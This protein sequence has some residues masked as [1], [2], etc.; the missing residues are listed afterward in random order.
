MP[1][2]TTKPT[3]EALRTIRFHPKKRKGVFLSLPPEMRAPL[4]TR[5]TKHVLFDLL[6]KLDDADITEALEY[7]GPDQATDILQCI[8]PGRR[9]KIIL[10]LS[11][12]LK[13]DVQTLLEFDPQTAA[14]LMNL[15]YIQ[16][17]E[18]ETVAQ[19]AKQ[20][21]IHEKRTGRSPV[22]LVVRQG[23][24]AG[25]LPGHELG[26]ALPSESIKKYIRRIVSIHHSAR[27]NDIIELFQGHPH[28]KIVVLGDKGNIIG[29]IYSD[30][31]L[32]ALEEEKTASLYD[33]AG[34]HDEETVDESI[35]VKVRLRYKW[36][37]IN[38]ATAFLAAFTVGIFDQ[39]IS[40]Y[41]LLAV[42][43]PII[44]GM[45]GNA[46]TQT[47]AVMVRGIAL[48]QITLK[49]ALPT[50][51][52]ELGA[53]FVNGIINGIIVAGVVMALNKN[54][55]IALI[56]G[57]AMIINLL[58]AGF[59][60]TMVPLLMKRFGKDPATSATIF[61]TTATDV[62]GFIAFLGMATIFLD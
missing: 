2:Q 12:R 46:A 40:K 58:V 23:K 3:D 42:Y 22:I 52:R 37:I 45:G 49:T 4:L 10:A 57:L 18:Y 60:G 48:K 62:L 44:A 41:I 6:A 13:Q 53:G 26:F 16:S 8:E 25:Y 38:L 50:L 31:V 59:F 21:K 9:K 36:L 19:V 30:D 61:I 33:F 14:G 34:V 1:K 35:K 11:E 5:L 7:L 20:F 43:M 39:T 56:L 27:K 24:L 54:I 32:R 17:E 29:L 47:L 55:R 28:N 15:D 51:K